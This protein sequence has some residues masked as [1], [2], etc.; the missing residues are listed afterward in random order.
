MALMGSACI[1]GYAYYAG[2]RSSL[3]EIHVFSLKSGH[4]MLIRT[5][6]DKRILIDGGSNTE[7]IR[8]LTNILPFYSRRLDVIIATGTDDKDVSGLI[9][10][11]E[12]YDVDMVYVPA[13]TLQNIGVKSSTDVAY[14][15]FMKVVEKKGIEL[16]EFKRGDSSNLDDV[17]INTLFPVQSEQFSYSKASFPEILFQISYRDT[18]ILYI[19]DASMKVQKHI[20]STSAGMIRESDV[21]IMSQAATTA[22]LSHILI[23][24]V[25]PDYLI[26]SQ[27]L[28][29]SV[30]SKKTVR[31]IADP[32]VGILSDHRFNLR[33]RGDVKIVSDGS[34]VTIS[35]E[36]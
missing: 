8:H 16:Q 11:L 21:M 12:R 30:P 1:T 22:N 10:V 20:A 35:T 24:G 5:P 32:L 3:L 18:S 15:T 2:E 29:R 27:V 33:E 13:Y 14:Q 31:S 25:R 23:D 9:D 17:V 36:K 4:S 26:H 6:H 7:I 28:S 34:K 19:G